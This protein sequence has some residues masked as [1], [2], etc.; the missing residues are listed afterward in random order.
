MNGIQFERFI[1]FFDDLKNG[2]WYWNF[3]K[4]VLKIDDD[5]VVVFFFNFLLLIQKIDLVVL[6]MVVMKITPSIVPLTY[7]TKN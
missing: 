4:I 5:V 3:C 2:N 1:H 6:V 7:L